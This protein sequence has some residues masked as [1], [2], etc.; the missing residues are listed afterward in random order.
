MTRRIEEAVMAEIA[1][2]D[3][4]GGALA[5]I[6]RGHF[7]KELARE[8]VAR[9]RALETGERRLVGQNFAVREE[10]KRAIDIFRLDPETERRQ[11][12]RLREVKARRNAGKVA[13]T[14]DAVRDAAL[15]G[16]NLVPP[17]LEAVK[18]YATQGEICDVLRG[19]F[20]T[21]TPDTLTSGV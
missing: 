5:A 1:K 18:V 12:E 16:E 14:L 7:Q 10:A 11:I 8:Q 15:S 3:A 4:M 21:Y 19:V 2:I 13:E 17:I 20:G 9:N 6:Q